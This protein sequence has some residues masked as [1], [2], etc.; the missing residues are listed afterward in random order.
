MRVTCEI[1]QVKQC[2]A[3]DCAYNRDK[4]CH[5]LAITI[6]QSDNPIC[7]TYLVSDTHTTTEQIGGVGSCKVSSCF[8]NA[9]FEC[10]ADGIQVDHASSEV[11][12]KTYKRR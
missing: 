10:H 3:T 8:H 9:D 6:G 12:C 1:P 5:A 7:N 2:K 11:V 4:A